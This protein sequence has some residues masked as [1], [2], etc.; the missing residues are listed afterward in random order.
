MVLF[1]RTAPKLS[2]QE[3][4]FLGLLLV[5]PTLDLWRNMPLFSIAKQSVNLTA[6]LAF[7]LATVSIVILVPHYKKLFATPLA[8]VWL[9][10]IALSTASLVYSFDKTSTVLETLK[11]IDLGAA[12]CAGFVLVKNKAEFS[13]TLSITIVLASVVPILAALY[14]WITETGLTIDQTTNRIYGTFAHP[15]ILA[16]FC[17]VTL[18]GIAYVFKNKSKKI[19][20]P[21]PLWTLVLLFVIFATYTRIA[22][23][24]L[25]VWLALYILLTHKKIFWWL[26]TSGVFVAALSTGIFAVMP[27]EFPTEFTNIP[28]VHRLIYR[29]ANADSIEWRWWVTRDSL[30]IFAMRPVFGF[31]Y[32]TFPVVWD[33]YKDKA[34]RGDASSEA[35]N[36]YTRIAIE[37]GLAGLAAYLALF[38]LL[39]KT[40]WQKK[41]ESTIFLI[42]IAVYCIV[43]ISENM[44]HH[45]AP[46]WWLWALW[47]AWSAD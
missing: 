39:F 26:C 8:L 40:A 44:L 21:L 43:A 6:V 47:G 13:T 35:H 17:L 33:T 10:F 5:R 9:I 4:L 23:L 22:W 38:V 25:L 12:F 36:D 16:L 20:S 2:W 1:S 32:G 11:L 15:N 29:P 24:A 41:S 37:E 28:L 7:C 46:A 31:G 14:Q 34:R 45:T 30:K 19:E 42:S 3:T 18:G 27:N